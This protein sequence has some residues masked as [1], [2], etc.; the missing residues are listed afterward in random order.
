MINQIHKAMH[1]VNKGW[2]PISREVANEFAE[3]SY[4]LANE[5]DIN[6]ISTHVKTLKGLKVLDIGGGPGY[7]S[8]HFARRGCEVTWYDISR[9]YL[10]IVK[11]RAEN[12]G[13]KI[14]YKLGYM[15]DYPTVEQFDIIF[16]HLCWYYGVSDRKMRD[17]LWRL[18]KS[19]GIIY[20]LTD[21]QETVRNPKKDIVRNLIQF[22]YRTFSYKIWHPFPPL[23]TISKL[24]LKLTPRDLET[25][26]FR[27]EHGRLLE[28]T[29][30]IK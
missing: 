6:Y 24:F 15:E 26:I 23:G 13:V 11:A 17:S 2:D 18:T 7:F 10:N 4:L 27:N 5:E 12:E 8:I 30:I 21:I 9:N 20:I 28:R 22:I 1:P 3:K 25:L 14:Q 29:L 16:V 19:G